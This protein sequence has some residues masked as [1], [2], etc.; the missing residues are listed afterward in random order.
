[1]LVEGGKEPRGGGASLLNAGF[2]GGPGKNFPSFSV[3]PAQL[4][5]R[6]GQRQGAKGP[7]RGPRLPGDLIAEPAPGWNGV[8]S[9]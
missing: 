9:F 5:L 1:M 7:R 3:F 2:M 6:P 8:D 4:S